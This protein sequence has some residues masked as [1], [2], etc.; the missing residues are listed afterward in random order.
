MSVFI[1]TSALFAL[2][3][4]SDHRH[5]EAAA[6]W[7]GLLESGADLETHNY[8]VSEIA[9]LAQRRLGTKVFTP[10]FDGLLAMV[11]VVWVDEEIHRRAVGAMRAA[12]KS[13]LSL[14]DCVSFEIMR[15]RGCE[16]AFAFDRHFDEHGFTTL[17]P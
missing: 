4:E 1:D 2:L 16:S 17:K 8:V 7:S 11:R 13:G 12:A 3:D 9:A 6:I 14:V 15:L 10:L 5:R